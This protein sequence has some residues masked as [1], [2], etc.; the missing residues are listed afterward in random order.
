MIGIEGESILKMKDTALAFLKHLLSS[1]IEK[2]KI[3]S[4]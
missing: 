1:W 4:K 2:T 3:R